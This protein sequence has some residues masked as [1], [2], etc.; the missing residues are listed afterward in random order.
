MPGYALLSSFSERTG[1]DRR[2]LT[3]HSYAQEAPYQLGDELG[4]ARLF[5]LS[6]GGVGM[7]LSHQVVPG[8]L[9]SLELP[10][11]ANECWRLKLAE[12]VHVTPN[13]P[14]SWLVGSRFTR[15][16]SNDVLEGLLQCSPAGNGQ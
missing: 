4:I 6:A 5:D 10:D 15:E 9:V 16:L 2:A 3:R 1:R 7:V 8:M 13:S 11:P 14:D 12:V